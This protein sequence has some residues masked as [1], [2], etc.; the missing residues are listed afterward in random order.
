MLK[1]KITGFIDDI[2]AIEGVTACALVSRDGIMIG[3]HFETELNE[4]WFA[5]MSATLLASAES[6]ANI[7]RV[8]SP[9]SVTVH[10]EDATIIVMG[11]GEK[12][13]VTAIVRKGADSSSVYAGMVPI[14]KK[15]AEV[16]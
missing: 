5:A 14:A 16:L 8:K 4:P 12:L 10:A 15:A 6:A 9:D 13:L 3:K 7:I 2:C 1:E 11:A